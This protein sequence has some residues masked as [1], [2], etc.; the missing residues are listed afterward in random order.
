M[1]QSTPSTPTSLVALRLIGGGRR[2]GHPHHA[3]TG[4]NGRAPHSP[5]S[6]ESVTRGTFIVQ[7]LIN[8]I[9]HCY[10]DVRTFV[11]YLKAFFAVL[12]SPIFFP[13]LGPSLASVF[14]H[15]S[16]RP[17]GVE[18]RPISSPGRPPGEHTCPCNTWEGW[19]VTR[20]VPKEEK[21][22][23]LS[24]HEGQPVRSGDVE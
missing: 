4:R 10:Q 16:R 6:C 9:W 1:P 13:L 7:I 2:S 22:S 12:L 18:A 17:T 5:T 15:S 21:G 24:V 14:L 20:G 3:P 11:K 23:H 8:L 19:A